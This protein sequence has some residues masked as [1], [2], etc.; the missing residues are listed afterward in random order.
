MVMTTMMMM[1]AIM[2]ITSTGVPHAAADRQRLAPAPGQ[3]GNLTTQLGGNHS[4]KMDDGCP[5]VPVLQLRQKIKTTVTSVG[6]VCWELVRFPNPV[7][8]QSGSGW[9]NLTWERATAMKLMD[10]YS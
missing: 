6:A 10:G 8:A 2:M 1:M 9:D 5:S 4:W 7:L 3:G